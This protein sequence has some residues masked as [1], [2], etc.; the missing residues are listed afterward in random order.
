MT[1][2]LGP[3]PRLRHNKGNVDFGKVFRNSII[4]PH[5]NVESIKKCVPTFPCI[6]TLGVKVLHYF[7]ILKPCSRDQISSIWPHLD[8]WKGFEK[9]I[10]KMGSTL[11]F[12]TQGMTKL[13][14][15]EFKG[16]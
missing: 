16:I 3:W 4:L 10:S 1:F 2:A 13:N 12:E 15:W 14:D 11:K 7:K 8:F 5:F 9:Y 6:P